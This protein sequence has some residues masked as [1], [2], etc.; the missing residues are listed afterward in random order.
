MVLRWTMKRWNEIRNVE[1]ARKGRKRRK[2]QGRMKDKES[3]GVDT[4]KEI[5]GMRGEGGKQEF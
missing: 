4:N 1:K 3:A 2:G 5:F